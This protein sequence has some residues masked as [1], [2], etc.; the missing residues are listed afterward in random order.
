M[1]RVPPKFPEKMEP[2]LE[3][4]RSPG[5]SAVLRVATSIRAPVWR[6]SAGL[7]H[8]EHPARAGKAD[9]EVQSRH[10]ALT[11]PEIRRVL[12]YGGHEGAVHLLER[13][14]HHLD[15]VA[16]RGEHQGEDLGLLTLG[17]VFRLPAS[18]TR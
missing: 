9:G 13:L 12:A 17:Q 1:L 7:P 16:G 15:V 11:A 2:R 14:A 8:H 4:L 5:S 6:R 10:L 18:G 3:K